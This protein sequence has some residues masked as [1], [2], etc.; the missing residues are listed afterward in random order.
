[1]MEHRTVKPAIVTYIVMEQFH[2]DEDEAAALVQVRI[3]VL[4][5]EIVHLVI[6]ITSA[7]HVLLQAAE[8]MEQHLL[9]EISLIHH[10]LTN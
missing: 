3:S 4:I 6:M 9:H 7:D 1:M 8:H 5:T 10:I 2:H